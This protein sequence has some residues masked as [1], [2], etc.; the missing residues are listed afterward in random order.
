MLAASPLRYSG[1][2]YPT[3][4]RGCYAFMAS[5]TGALARLRRK[6]LVQGDRGGLAA[7]AGR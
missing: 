7:L 6:G 5:L 1:A 3:C 4:L 2:F